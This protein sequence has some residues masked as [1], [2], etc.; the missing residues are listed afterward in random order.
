MED[1]LLF[2]KHDAAKAEAELKFEIE[3]IKAKHAAI[4]SDTRRATKCDIDRIQDHL[5]SLESEKS[6]LL[7]K[8]E[9]FSRNLE[10]SNES[11]KTIINQISATEQRISE[12]RAKI[13]MN[14]R[15]HEQI[16][17]ERKEKVT[18]LKA[19][20]TKIDISFSHK[21]T[22]HPSDQEEVNKMNLVVTASS[23]CDTGACHEDDDEDDDDIDALTSSSFLARLVHKA[24]AHW[25]MEADG[26]KMRSNLAEERHMTSCLFTAVSGWH[27]F[28]Q[29]QRY[30]DVYQIGVFRL[31]RALQS[32]IRYKRQRQVQNAIISKHL[33]IKT[34]YGLCSCCCALAKQF[35]PRKLKH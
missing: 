3:R 12:T 24:F 21:R 22:A 7:P 34:R 25:K 30:K 33:D 35:W 16:I 5:I 19:P 15:L 27:A 23:S 20:S 17:R 14:Q 1:T 2:T 10:A 28:A 18:R 26:A 9:H 4:Q 13:E 8:L 29:S 31:S 6:S 11:V 32:W